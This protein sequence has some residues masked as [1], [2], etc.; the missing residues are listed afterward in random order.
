MCSLDTF[1]KD[2]QIER[3][4]LLKMDVQGG[5]LGILQ[6]A[7]QLLAQKKIAV[8]Y[9]EVFFVPMYQNQPLFG[10]SELAPHRYSLH[11]AY[12]FVFNGRSGRL[13]SADALFVSPDLL[14]QSKKMLSGYNQ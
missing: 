10:C 9:S 1:C 13:F 2:E 6:G 11:Y 12:N 8:I 4:D 7:R 5:E 14:G 3:I